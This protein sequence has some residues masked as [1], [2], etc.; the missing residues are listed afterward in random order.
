MAILVIS[1]VVLFAPAVQAAD[2]GRFV[3]DVVAQ[4]LD[5]GRAMKLREPFGYEAKDGTQWNV[6]KDIVIDGAT[7]P[8]VFWSFIG[9]PFAGKYR[10]ASVIHDYFCDT[11]SRPW[12]Q[13]HLVF[14]EAMLTAGVGQE[15]AYLMYKAVENFGPRWD[16]PK[17]DPACE[18]A[19]G[20]IDFE[21]CA[22]NAR[23]TPPVRYPSASNEEIAG[24]LKAMEGQANREDLDAIG[25]AL[26]TQP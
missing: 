8:S 20:S 21:N 11:R 2:K 1:S 6:P 17:L 15:R 16:P 3:G 23:T 14:Y 26:K 4:W 7:I 25:K 10:P 12:Q 24:F 18:R 13:V 5:N 9:G 22:M 19:D